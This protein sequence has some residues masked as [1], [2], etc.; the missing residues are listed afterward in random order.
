MNLFVEFTSSINNIFYSN[1]L[2]NMPNIDVGTLTSLQ[3]RFV[4][5]EQRYHTLIHNY[6][7]FEEFSNNM[8]TFLDILS[9]ED[10]TFGK[11]DCLMRYWF[12]KL[13]IFFYELLFMYHGLINFHYHN[14]DVKNP[15]NEFYSNH[16]MSKLPNCFSQLADAGKLKATNFTTD[17]CISLQVDID[18]YVE[19][20]KVFICII[21]IFTHA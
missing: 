13:C 20:K 7:K 9:K 21:H 2:E 3:N 8:W 16:I 1:S 17:S 10:A 15:T 18:K 11:V 6:Q 5:V 12:N 19:S 4:V 14:V